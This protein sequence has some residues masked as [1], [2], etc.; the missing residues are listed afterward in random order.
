MVTDLRCCI[1]IAM[2][3]FD[4][5]RKYFGT[6]GIR[7]EA[8]RFPVV[9]EMMLKLGMAAGAYF[10]N[11]K[12]KPKIVIGKDTRL[13]GYM[14]EAALMSGICS[15]GTDVYLVGP[16]PTPA[17]AFITRSMRADAGIVISASHN[18]FQ[19]NGIKFFGA[20]GMKLPD[21]AEASLESLM[22]NEALERPTREKVGR[23][24]RIDDAE[25]RYIVYVKS[26]IPKEISLDGIKIVI[27]CAN[28]AGYEV[29]PAVFGE[30]GAEVVTLGCEPDGLNINRG[31]GSTDTD[32]MV[33]AVVETGSDLGLAL[34]G[35]GDRIILADSEGTIVDGDDI[36]YLC[37]THL[38]NREELEP[39]T[40]I[41]TVMTNMGLEAALRKEGIT[42]IRAP[43]GDRYV[44]EEIKD[45]WAVL[46]GEPSGHLIFSRYSTT[47]DGILSGLQVLRVMVETRKPLKELCG[48]WQRFPQVMK[49]LR[50]KE[51]KPL[52]D[53]EWYEKLLSRAR[54][55]MG[56]NHL[57][58][59]RYSGTEALLRVTVSCA[60]ED[61][62]RDVCESICE[63]LVERLG[64]VRD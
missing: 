5:K 25:G 47:G 40:V 15:M 46:G 59:L 33:R 36:L 23:A 17:I 62:T 31:C 45:A 26:T 58:N 8:N 43:V 44:M 49:N 55:R 34:D 37:A 6:D 13:S 16:M 53:Q 32:A 2:H 61:L 54:E 14:I 42:L 63:E 20:D 18:P 35:D 30:L 4:I 51:R 22:D 56:E 28:G 1:N 27:D 50:V 29:A 38:K 19:D 7:G 57:L 11:R 41:G 9:P 12:E 48:G 10:H 24:F 3:S 52:E 39:R 60:S 21:E 64:E